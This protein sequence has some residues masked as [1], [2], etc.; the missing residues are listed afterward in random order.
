MKKEIQE[1]LKQQWEQINLA[2]YTVAIFGAGNTSLLYQRT[3]EQE[4]LCDYVFLDR[5][6]L[7]QKSLFLGKPVLS[8]SDFLTASTEKTKLVFISSANIKVCNQIK[9]E[10]AQFD[11]IVRTVDEYV[12]FNRWDEILKVV[13]S[14]EDA[15]SKNTYLELIL[16]R[17]KNQKIPTDIFTPNPYFCLPEFLDYEAS[18]V[19]VDCRAYVGDTVEKYISIKAGVFSKIF[20]FEPEPRNH[21]AFLFRQERLQ[22]EWA[23]PEGRIILEKA[24]VGGQTR[25]ASMANQNMEGPSLG[26]S[27]NGESICLGGEENGVQI[28][29]LDD[30]FKNQKIGFLKADIESYELDM[31]KGAIHVIKRDRPVLAICIYHNASDMWEIPL[32]LKQELPD[33][34]FKVRHHLYL[35]LDTVLYAYPK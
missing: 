22:N 24:G 20:A 11:C 26:A 21:Q 16:A 5:D 30:Y 6:P 12:F 9:A 35:L 32:W 7:K 29:A 10:L 25:Y 8:P 31:L 23:I 18:E 15:T 1:F 14:L 33:Y 17:A 34:T 27:F 2:D 4:F 19:F 28:Y 3:F 13:D